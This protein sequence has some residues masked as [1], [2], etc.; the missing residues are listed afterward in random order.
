M[1]SKNLYVGNLPFTT[2]EQELTDLFSQYGTV[3]KSQVIQDRET[4]R[5]RGFGFV[6]MSSGA[7]EAVQAMNGA[8][9]QGRRL[10]VNE[11]KP[12]EERGGGG[13]YGGG[14][15]RGGY[16]GGGGGGGRGGYGGG[17]GGRGGYGGGGGGGGYGGGGGG[18]RY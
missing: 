13:G 2:T 9:Y 6:E 17:G 4:G 16:G 18:S 5:S 3:T 8:E 11:A 7:E 10:T 12:R 1:A 14:G 15:G